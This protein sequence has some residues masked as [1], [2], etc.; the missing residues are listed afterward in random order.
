VKSAAELSLKKLGVDFIDLYYLHRADREVPI[1]ETVGAMAELVKQGKVRYIGLSEISADTLRRAHAVHPIAAVQVEYSPFCLGIESEEI[2][3][4]KAC[5]ELGVAI[6]CYSPLGR[7][8]LTGAYKS[9]D[10]IPEDD[11][12]RILPKYSKENFPQVLKFVD[13]IHEVGKKH[14]IT[15]GQVTLAW[16]LAQG[17]DVIPIPGTKKIKYLKENLAAAK[18]KLSDKEVEEIREMAEKADATLGARYPPQY[19]EFSFIDTPPLPLI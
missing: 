13:D 5:R 19:M 9:P 12:R 8:I 6:V 1:E 11:L 18:V 14:D 3:L 7:G 16:L 10:D 2:G 4:L 17:N 15:P